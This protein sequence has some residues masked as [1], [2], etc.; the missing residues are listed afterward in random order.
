MLISKNNVT[1]NGTSCWNIKIFFVD[2]DKSTNFHKPKTIEEFTNQAKYFNTVNVIEVFK[3]INKFK[4][5]GLLISAG[6]FTN[7]VNNLSISETLIAFNYSEKVAEYGTYNFLINGFSSIANHFK[8]TVRPIIITK[9]N[10]DYDIGTGFLIGNIHTLITA[11]HIVEEA[12]LIQI[13]DS[14]GNYINAEHII[15]S[16]DE[17]I[18]IAIILVSNNSF[19][20]TP[21]FN[22]KEAEILEDVLTIG[23]PPIPGFDSLQIYEIASVNNSFKFSKGK[24]IGRDTAYLDGVEYLIMNA[25]VK[26]GNSGS[27]VINKN[28]NVIGMVVQIPIDV[29]DSSKLDSLGYGIIT[30]KSEILKL[31]NGSNHTPEIT[32]HEVAN[33]DNGFKIIK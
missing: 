31:L 14:D 22:M 5:E 26:G 15:F 4:L 33:F 13:P 32:I 6:Y 27:P 7:T 28:G 23:Y 3:I 20:G 18:D 8:N 12:E 2:I 9:Q 11:K 16:K 25:K 30:P 19:L 1:W 29:E 24:L 17:K 21:H 10:G